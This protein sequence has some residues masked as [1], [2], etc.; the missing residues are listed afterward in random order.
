MA[1]IVSQIKPY[2]PVV[3]VV[4]DGWG[5]GKPGPWNAITQAK[6]PNYTYLLKRY[7]N[8]SLEAGGRAVGLSKGQDGNSEAGHMNIGAGRVVL[9]DEVEISRAITTGAFFRNPAFI[10]A[11]RHVQKHNSTLHLIGMMGNNQ[12][13]HASPDHLLALLT[14]VRLMRLKHVK[15]HIFTDGR[16]SP[17]FAAIK[18]L[19]MLEMELGNTRIASVTGRY[20]AMDRALHWGRI[21]Q[22][23]DLLT[24]GSGLRATSPESAILEAYNR[25]GSDE[26][27][28]P[29]AVV[30]E[31]HRPSVVKD[32][33]SIIFF[34]LR[35]DRARQLTKAF[36][37]LDFSGFRRKKI[38]K[39][40]VFVA[41]TDFGPDLPGVLSAFPSRDIDD[42]LPMV[43]KGY[44]QLYVSESE[45]YA[46][47]TYFFNGGYDH[48]VAGE[49]RV[50]IPS[51]KVLT[52]DKRPAMSTAKVTQY[53]I[54][55][56]KKQAHDF[57]AL[58]YAAPDM[59]AHTG[60]MHA[61]IKAVE[62]VDKGLGI[63]ERAVRKAHG[64]LIIT[65][66][67][68]NIEELK[69]I[70]TGEV[71]TEHS[72]TPV[73]FILVNK[74]YKKCKLR[75]FGCLANIAPTILDLMQVSKPK[76]MIG[77]SLLIK[78]QKHEC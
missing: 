22:T 11:I 28:M 53:V 34:N 61:S 70:R 46:H 39:N 32:N 77:K 69:N 14:F 68:G 71:D 56:L 36:V 13:A 44:R 23:Y 6:T 72:N 74:N 29:T 73:P 78:K 57:I 7:P 10:R 38:I 12:S 62:A 67:H 50:S 47:M 21:K 76:L 42:T 5:I 4:I 55:D 49:D 24:L 41:M 66:D 31:G 9:Q 33:D 45:K 58:N 3:L 48:P 8:T 19:K 26:F 2:L 17:R 60:H 35:S 40:L 20:Y 30:P 16:D 25:N 52:Y 1:K 37:Q 18:I 15:L 43:L 59:V 65:A 54:R 75:K 51:P 27:I 63:L 64:T